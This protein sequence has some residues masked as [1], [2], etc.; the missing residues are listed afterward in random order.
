MT[1]LCKIL[2]R[3]PDQLCRR[4]AIR[5]GTTS[6]ASQGPMAGRQAEV[7]KRGFLQTLPEALEYIWQGYPIK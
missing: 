1:P 2:L 5:N 6:A 4:A 3:F 7:T